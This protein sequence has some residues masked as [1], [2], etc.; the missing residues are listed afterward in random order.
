M[1]SS[2]RFVYGNIVT[3][4]WFRTLGI[5]LRAGRDFDSR[6]QAGTKDVAIVDE[7]FVRQLLGAGNPVG[8][9]I[10][11]IDSSTKRRPLEIVGVVTNA[12][13]R[14]IREAPPPTLY[15]PVTQANDDFL[16]LPTFE[17]IVRV[18][19]GAPS[20]ATRSVTAA[21]E[22]IHPDLTLAVRTLS[23][24]IDAE[25]LN[26][27]LVAH[28]GAWFGG[29]ALALAALGLYGITAYATTVRRVEMGIR[30]AIGAQRVDILSLILRQSCML[31]AIGVLAGITVSLLITQYLRTMLFGVSSSDPMTFIGVTGLLFAVSTSAAYIPAR[32][33]AR[34]DPVVSLRYE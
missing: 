23:D 29:L 11:Q 18:A 8:R 34:V 9:T 33:A 14:S 20:Q 21:I 13:Y 5:Q 22:R 19:S 12:A 10:W 32:R 4:G 6:D 26:T 1:S 3:P 2:D 15:V 28:I 16:S 25:L 27:R 24:Q 31:V 7:A 17:V 30:M